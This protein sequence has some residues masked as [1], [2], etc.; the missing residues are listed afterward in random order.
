MPVTRSQR[1][2]EAGFSSSAAVVQDEAEAA[3]FGFLQRFASTF[4]L[5]PS[6][7]PRVLQHIKHHKYV[8][9]A[10]TPLDNY[11]NDWWFKVHLLTCF[12]RRQFFN[13]FQL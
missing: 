12:L 10:Y 4:G 8:S 13:C 7:S 1:K 5:A 6:L 11:L 9:G 3:E 2:K